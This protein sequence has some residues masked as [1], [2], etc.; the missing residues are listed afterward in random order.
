M[1]SAEGAVNYLRCY[2]RLDGCLRRV[3]RRYFQDND[4]SRFFIIRGIGPGIGAL[5]FWMTVYLKHCYFSFP[6]SV[7]VKTQKGLRN[8][9]SFDV[10]RLAA[11]QLENGILEASQVV[12]GR[13]AAN[14]WHLRS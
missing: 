3:N 4:I 14:F 1:E 5:R 13:C 10:F 7:S 12:V 11:V 9:Y 2:S 8:G 6:N